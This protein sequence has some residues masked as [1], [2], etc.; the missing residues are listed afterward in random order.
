MHDN[1]LTNDVAMTSSPMASS[2]TPELN[3]SACR[4]T[5]RETTNLGVVARDGVVLKKRLQNLETLLL[6]INPCGRD[7][8]RTKE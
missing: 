7:S 5:D 4:H 2:M 1:L 6:S 3:V 8:A